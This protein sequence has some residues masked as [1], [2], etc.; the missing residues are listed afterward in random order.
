M[1]PGSKNVGR[2]GVLKPGRGEQS[3]VSSK[4]KKAQR[5]LCL[6]WCFEIRR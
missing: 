4:K 3:A 5:M 6:L 2:G 1:E